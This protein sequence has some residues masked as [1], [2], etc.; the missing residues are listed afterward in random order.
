MR[1]DEL[2][3]NL[4]NSARFSA[5]INDALLLVTNLE[6][7]SE[8]IIEEF[9]GSFQVRQAICF[10]CLEW[11]GEELLSLYGLCSLA[12]ERFSGCKMFVDR[13]GVLVMASDVLATAASVEFIEIILGQIEFMSQAMLGLVETIRERGAAITE[14]EIDSALESPS[15]Q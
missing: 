7:G 2:A 3:G 4:T 11:T 5:T 1:I 14:D 15:V 12:N 13:W 9:D 8:Y 10:D 6:T